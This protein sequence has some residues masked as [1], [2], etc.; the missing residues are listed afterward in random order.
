[1]KKWICYNLLGENPEAIDTFGI[2]SGLGILALLFGSW[3]F[4]FVFLPLYIW[5]M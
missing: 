3:T 4:L 2:V 5:I 1:M